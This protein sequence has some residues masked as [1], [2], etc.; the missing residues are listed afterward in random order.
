MDISLPFRFRWAASHCQDATNLVARELRR[1]GISLLN[2]IDGF[3]GVASSRSE[4]ESLS[5]RVFWNPWACGKPATKLPLLLRSWCGW[6]VKFDT[7]ARTVTLP[8]DKLSEIMYLVDCW[9]HKSTANVHDLRSLLGKLLFVG[10]CCP[11]AGLFTNRMLHDDYSLPFINPTIPTITCYITISLTTFSQLAA[12]AIMSRV[13]GFSTENWAWP[14][15]LY[16]VF[17]SQPSCRPLTSPCGYLL[18]IAYPSFPSFS[19]SFVNCP[20]V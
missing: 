18:Y 3:G 11:P 19:Y 2:Y 8:P 9:G 4:A 10:Q 12:S 1:R 13:S 17:L 15:F 14:Q 5:S 20:P 7:L 16:T 6:V